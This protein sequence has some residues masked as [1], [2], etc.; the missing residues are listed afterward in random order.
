MSQLSPQQ[1]QTV[2]ACYVKDLLAGAEAKGIN[3]EPLLQG[4]GLN[5][6][7]LHRRDWRLGIDQYVRLTQ[8]VWQRTADESGG[9][10]ERPLKPGTFAMLCHATIGCSNLRKALQLA[11]RFFHL[12]TDDLH[13]Q[14]AEQDQQTA[15]IISQRPK[16]N[17][18]NLFFIETL[19]LILIRW[20]SWM[21]DRKLLVTRI[22]F[23]GDRGEDAD[24][25]ASIFGC[26][27]HFNQ[28]ENKITFPSRFLQ[29]RIVQDQHQ[30]NQFLAKAPVSLLS[31]YRRDTSLSAQVR[32]LIQQATD[33]D[34]TGLENVGLE[35]MAEHLHL[36]SQTLRRRLKEEG[37]SFQQI[38]DTVRC[39]LAMHL[40][41]QEQLPMPEIV[42]RMGFSEPSVFYKAFKRWTGVTPGVFR[43]QHIQKRKHSIYMKAQTGK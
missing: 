29:E 26:T 38:K 37:N 14:L 33:A 39:N 13:I 23:Q 34:H 43:E 24:E 22:D 1:P 12:L 7:H 6:S 11:I 9:Y 27:P 10:T 32:H 30:L 41:V 17:L 8:S 31:H 19:S 18:N 2:A 21:I 16:A 42:I 15:L 36:T 20:A 40:L 28:P 4:V 3:L 25:C 35:Q 5:P